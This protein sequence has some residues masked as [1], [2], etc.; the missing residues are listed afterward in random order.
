M[1]EKSSSYILLPAEKVI[2]MATVIIERINEIR[3]DD[4]KR[5]IMNRKKNMVST[6]WNTIFNRSYAP[7][8][9][10]AHKSLMSD[11]W[12]FHYP[13]TKHSHQMTIA[14]RLRIAAKMIDPDAEMLISTNDLFYIVP[15]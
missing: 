14:K 9:E 8:D 12:Y 3:E 13:S 5:M 7:T 1:D 11:K 10:E 4:N 15:S 6:F 2:D